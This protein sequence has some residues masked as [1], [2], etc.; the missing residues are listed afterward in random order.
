[1]ILIIT[2]IILNILGII[3]IVVPALPGIILNYLA[4]FL[5]Y[6]SRGEEAIGL[7]ALIMFG[8]LTLLVALLDYILP[9]AGAKKLGASRTGII[10]AVIG[11]ITGMIFFPP[12]GIF[13]GLLIGAFVGE[14][15][16]GKSQ[17]QAFKAGFVTFLGIL[18]SMVV[19]LMLAVVMTVYYL[20]HSF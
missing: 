3:G 7:S 18:T 5:L 15:I 10:F 1:M 17:S 4:L 9:L 20:W 8:L 12:F 11:M 6:I 13:F 19:K 14:L 16:A 2:G